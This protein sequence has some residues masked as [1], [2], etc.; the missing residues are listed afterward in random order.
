[1]R[2]PLSKASPAASSS[3]L[4]STSKPSWRVDPRQQRVAAAGDQAHERRLEGP[5]SPAR[6]KFAATWPCRW[7]TA[8]NGSSPRRR[9]RLRAREADE[10]RAD[11]ARALGGGHQLDLVQAAAGPRQG[12]VDDGVDQLEVVAR[13][14]LG[15]DP[16]EAGVLLL[17]G[18]HVGADRAVLLQDRRAGVV[19]AGLEREDAHGGEALGTSS[20]DPA[21]VAGVRHMTSASSPLSW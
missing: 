20:S 3:V 18:D 17:G 1:M 11:Q 15:H 5:R 9:D 10:Q 6:R 14:D 2:A 19:A 7:S 16:A 12:L 4:P 13:G 8:A 21:R